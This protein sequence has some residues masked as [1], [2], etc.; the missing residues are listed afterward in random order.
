MKHSYSNRKP[1]TLHPRAALVPVALLLPLLLAGFLRVPT[2]VGPT[3][4]VAPAVQA[5]A[6]RAPLPYSSAPDYLDAGLQAIVEDYVSEAAGDW[7]VTVKKLDTGQYAAVNAE[8]PVVTASLYKIFVLDELMRQRAQGKIRLEDT[9]TITNEN[10]AYDAT[11]G[12]LH[13]VIGTRVTIADLINRMITV[14]DNTAAI[15]LARMVGVEQVNKSL[16]R[17]GLT[18]SALNFSGGDNMTT[19]ADFNRLLEWIATGQTVNRDASRYMIDVMLRQELNDQLPGGL[20]DGTPIA[21]KTGTLEDLQH[22]AGVVYGPSGP[23][24]ITV[25]SWNFPTYGGSTYLMKQL[26]AAVYKYFNSHEF[27]PARYFPE[28]RQV[29]GP[30]FLLFYSSNGGRPTFGLP[31][32]PET[33]TGNTIVQYFERAR[34]ERPAAGG[35]VTLGNVGRD[36]IS[37]RGLR[38]PATPAPNPADPNTI[39]FASTQQA[40]GQPFLDYWREHGGEAIFG[41]PLSGI[42]EEQRDGQ[43]WRAQYFERARFELHEDGVWLGLIGS[44]ML[45]P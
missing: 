40:I 22:D 41:R 42:V 15:T 27:T 29:V 4:A 36:L 39:W 3:A 35:P 21:H 38:F 24:V 25:M 43:T 12:E 18:D 37:R 1:Q 26:S 20:P 19:A 10:A 17:L 9:T 16:A 33:A 34:M 6:E 28:T 14:S 30:A 7:A 44:E 31:T 23:Y 45:A 13:W 2:A 32:G 11:I 5:Q 8:D